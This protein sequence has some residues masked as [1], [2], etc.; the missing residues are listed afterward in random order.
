MKEAPADPEKTSKKK[1]KNKKKAKGIDAFLEN[2]EEAKK[3]SQQEPVSEEP[4][5]ESAGAGEPFKRKKS[6]RFNME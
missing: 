3:F 4:P 5:Q 6:V 2:D 1:R